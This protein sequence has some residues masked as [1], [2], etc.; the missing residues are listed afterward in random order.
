[1][2][3]Q[4][5]GE[6]ENMSYSG[7]LLFPCGA[8]KREVLPKRLKETDVPLETITVYQTAQHP[9]IRPSLTHY[10]TQFAAIGPTTADAMVAEG[11]SVSC[12]AQNPSPQ[13]L[14]EGIRRVVQ[15]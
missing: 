13:G 7:P 8:L 11:L 5:L 12:T 10:F 15:Q 4:H 2:E 1:M 14:A 9:D 6:T 3:I